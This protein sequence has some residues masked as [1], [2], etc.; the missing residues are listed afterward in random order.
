MGS[1]AML[2]L[3]PVFLFPG[4]FGRTLD[5]VAS[6]ATGSAR[7]VAVFVALLFAIPLALVALF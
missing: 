6:L 4:A 7:A 2:S 3:P 5:H 1:V